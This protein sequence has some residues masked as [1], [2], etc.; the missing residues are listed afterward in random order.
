[1]ENMELFVNPRSVALI[2]ATDRESS[3]GRVCLENLLSGKDRRKIYPVNPNREKVFDMKCYPS[4]SALPESPELAV[5]I[6]PAVTVP[7]IVEESGKAGVKGVIIIAAG[8]KEI[9]A[10]GKAREDRIADIARKYGMRIIGPNCMG[11]MRPNTSFNTTFISRIPKAGYIAFLTQS[12]ALGSAAVNWA[13]SK[14]I[15]FSAFI[16]LGST[17]DVTFGDLIDYLG[18]DRETKSIIIHMESI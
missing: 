4:I 11:V 3:S 6:T 14:N 1:M 5:V 17:L 13:I 15:G 8:F 16:S 18:R 7:D 10:E 9:G 2:G 12:G